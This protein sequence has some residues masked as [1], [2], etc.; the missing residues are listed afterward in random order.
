MEYEPTAEEETAMARIMA[1]LGHEPTPLDQVAE[2][3][4]LSVA[5]THAALRILD[6]EGRIR[7]ERASG[8][9]LRQALYSLWP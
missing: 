8:R 7:S 1:T 6:K 9:G 4:E 5:A 3:A 2:R